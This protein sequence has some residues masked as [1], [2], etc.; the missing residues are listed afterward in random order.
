MMMMVM[1]VVVMVV[2]VMVM[3][4]WNYRGIDKYRFF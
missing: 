1:V 3:R 2:V 4:D